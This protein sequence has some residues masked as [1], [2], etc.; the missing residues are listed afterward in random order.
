MDA[1]KRIT[2][3]NANKKPDNKK[4]DNTTDDNRID[5]FVKK[6]QQMPYAKQSNL[7]CYLTMMMS[8]SVDIYPD[9]NGQYPKTVDITFS[10]PARGEPNDGNPELM[11]ILEL[12]PGNKLT[13]KENEYT[14]QR[15][16][17]LCEDFTVKW[18]P[19]KASAILTEALGKLKAN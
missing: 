4:T 16:I 15:A 17:W 8:H 18:D 2:R 19:K 5:E 14:R 7:I 3:S 1:N 9:A 10:Y 13:V 11:A 6:Y 12:I